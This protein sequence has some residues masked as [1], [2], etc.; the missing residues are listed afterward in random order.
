M[1]TFQRKILLKLNYKINCATYYKLHFT[2]F[3]FQIRRTIPY[4][5]GFIRSTMDEDRPICC[6]NNYR[7]HFD[8]AKL[9]AALANGNYKR[10]IFLQSYIISLQKQT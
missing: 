8:K 7:L 3:G 6:G 2:I 10:L 1:D 5:G 9:P 4:V